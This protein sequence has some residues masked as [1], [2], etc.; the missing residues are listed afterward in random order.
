MDPI[1]LRERSTRDRWPLIR[2][3]DDEVGDDETAALPHLTDAELIA[4]KLLI[5][6][7][8]VTWLDGDGLD[9][10]SAAIKAQAEAALFKISAALKA[11]LPTC[12]GE[13][14]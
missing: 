11:Q 9:R 2:F 8:L 13:S 10:Q 1:E 7:S 5:T 6:T 3:D 4:V 12:G 14:E